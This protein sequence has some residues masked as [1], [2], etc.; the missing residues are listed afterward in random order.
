[1]GK[2]LIP[3]SSPKDWK[4]LLAEPEKHWKRGY[5]AR[6]LAFCWQSA[7]DL[8][9]EVREVLT[10]SPDLKSMESIFCIPEHQVPLPG[11]SRP[12]QSDIWVLGRTQRGLVSIAVEGKVSESFGPTIG[13]WYADASA[14]KEKRL[15]FLCSELGLS[16]PP[17][18]DLRYQLFHRTASA[19][20]EAKTFHAADAVMLVHTFSPTDEWFSDYHYFLEQFGLCA[21]ANQ[22]VSTQITD[23]IRLHFAWVHGSS[24]WLEA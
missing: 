11:G 5:S 9:G 2:I 13:E 8:P 7:G 12:S 14:G 15:R 10:P 1:M 16:F 18:D 6:A 19:M 21:I 22:I 23:S 20:I 4:R 24:E 17:H 3:A